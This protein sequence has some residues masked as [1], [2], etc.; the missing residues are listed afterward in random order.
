MRTYSVGEEVLFDGERWV[1]SQT[2]RGSDP[3]APL[4]YRLLAT[5]PG[6][7]RFAWALP[8]QLHD[9]SSYLEPDDDTARY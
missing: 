2:L 9:M 5:S 7:A 6:G 8:H 1:V 3:E 4:R